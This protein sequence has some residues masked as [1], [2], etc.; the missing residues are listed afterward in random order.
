M[1]TSQVFL[2]ETPASSPN[3]ADPSAMAHADGYVWGDPQPPRAPRSWPK[4]ALLIAAGMVVAAGATYLVTSNSSSSGTSGSGPGRG[5]FPGGAPGAG[6]PAGGPG[7][8]NATGAQGGVTPDGA[9]SP[10][11]PAIGPQNG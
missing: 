11:P 6:F 3:P 4:S 5:G 10:G 8:G 9:A 1:S 7:G 2:V